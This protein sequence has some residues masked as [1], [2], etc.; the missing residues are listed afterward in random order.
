MEIIDCIAEQIKSVMTQVC[1]ESKFQIHRNLRRPSFSFT[2]LF[3]LTYF[4][5]VYINRPQKRSKKPLKVIKTTTKHKTL[6]QIYITGR[7]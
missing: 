1:K 7:L 3:K 6:S 2:Y 4:C 5:T